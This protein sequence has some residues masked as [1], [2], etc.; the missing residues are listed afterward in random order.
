MTMLVA[1]VA[2]VWFLSLVVVRID[3]E[4]VGYWK[5]EAAAAERQRW[6]IEEHLGPE[7]SPVVHAYVGPDDG[8]AASGVRHY[9]QG[10]TMITAVAEPVAQK[11]LDRIEGRID[12][13]YVQIAGIAERLEAVAKRLAG[14][15]ARPESGGSVRRAEHVVDRIDHRLDSIGHALDGLEAIVSELERV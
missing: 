3:G 9:G 8:W 6:A 11:K 13:T 4:R 14:T 2:V 1:G 15:E 5:G 12:G 10:T 7:A